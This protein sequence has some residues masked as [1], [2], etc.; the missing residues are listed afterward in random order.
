MIVNKCYVC[1]EEG[2]A[3]INHRWWCPLHLDDG[4]MWMWEVL[5]DG[6][7]PRPMMDTAGPP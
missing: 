1:A 6:D 3:R 4:F 7:R 5:D 2:I